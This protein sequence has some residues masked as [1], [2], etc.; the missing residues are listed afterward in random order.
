MKSYVVGGAVRDAL[1]GLPVK[2]HDHV[3]VGATPDQ[4]VALGYRPVGKDF[5]V[6][7]HPATQEEYALARTERK[8]APGYKGFV[9]HTAPEV[10]LEQDLVRRDL[11][12]NAIARAEDGTLTD[13]FGGQRDLADKIFRHVSEAFAE[14]PVRI[15]RVARFAARYPDFRVAPETNA[16]MRQMVAHGE[17]DAL[18]AERVWQ[19]L[20]R[21]LMEQRPSRMLEVLRDCGALAR[22]LPELDVLWGVPQPEKWHPEIDTG[23][24]IL[25]VIDCAAR[26]QLELPTRVACLLHDLGKGVTP[27]ASWP[28]HHGHEALGVKLVEQVCKRLRVPTDCRDLALMTAR[29]HGN[30][31]RALQLRPNTVVKLLERCDAFRKPAR[32]VQMLRATECDSR[33]RTGPS[34]SYHD[35]PFPQGAYLET[36]MAAARAVNAG[37]IAQTCRDQPQRIPEYVHRARVTAVRLALGAADGADDTAMAD[38]GNHGDHDA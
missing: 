13:P 17:V 22:I 24:H 18:V 6:F 26:A 16:L 15:L 23:V 20:S 7:L 3:V 27:S 5:P 21:G 11:T 38:H 28:A 31:G 35:A 9:F 29:E 4:M 2:D 12:I 25:Q 37:E 19:E 10:T 1:L 8:T 14:D 33:G 30:V 32:F 36:A 34:A